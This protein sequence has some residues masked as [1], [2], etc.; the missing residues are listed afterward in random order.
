MGQCQQAGDSSAHSCKR[1]NTPVQLGN[2]IH[3]D[4]DSWLQL[5]KTVD[6]LLDVFN[7]D[8]LLSAPIAHGGLYQ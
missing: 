4:H 6:E 1:S 5:P 2:C 3:R 8:V 7:F